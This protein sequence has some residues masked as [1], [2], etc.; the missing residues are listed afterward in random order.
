VERDNS[1]ALLGLNAVPGLGP[2]KFQQLLGG[3]GS[4]EAVVE[5]CPE[6]LYG[7]G[8]RLEKWSAQQIR[9]EGHVQWLVLRELG[10]QVLEEQSERPM[11]WDHLAQ[12][13]G[14]QPPPVTIFRGNPDCILAP[15]LRVAVVGS[16]A[17]TPYGR[18]QAFR[19]GAGL[20]AAGVVV[21][22]GA[23][24]GIDQAAMRGALSVGGQV[25]A[26][27]GSGLDR[28]YPADARNLLDAIVEEQGC[29]LTEFGCNTTP[30]RG[31]F[32]R[33]NR[34]I[35][36]LAKGT[37]VVEA[38]PKSG[39]MNTVDW[40]NQL[41]REVFAVPGPVNGIC[42]RGPH[43]LLREGAHFAENV[44]DVLAQ[45]EL[46]MPKEIQQA[47][48]PLLEVLDRGDL[49]LEGLAHE[50]GRSPDDLL[51]ELMELEIEGKLIRL[52]GGYYHR[53]GPAN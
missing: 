2:R 9:Q 43:Q 38:G 31:N 8:G 23:A 50:L 33:R 11:E 52:S 21:V 53:L 14:G 36:A 26:V 27:L 47:G 32:P 30:A 25:V 45:F 28:P 35:A 15:V 44:Q 16:R 12:I 22:S 5:A 3:Y 10:A 42:S 6:C 17:C 29:V 51:P 37:V 39:S 49:S 34:L 1:I 13:R 20:A 48:G 7:L 18:E 4:A 24:R 46:C 41:G 40:C 19:M